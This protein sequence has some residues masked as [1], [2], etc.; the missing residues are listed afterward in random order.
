MAS[1]NAV[2]QSRIQLHLRIRASKARRQSL[3]AFL[4]EAIPAYKAPGGIG[5]RLLEDLRDPERFIEVIDYS[6]PAAFETDQVRVETDATMI[7]LLDR[8]RR[9]LDG[10]VEIET[11]KDITNEVGL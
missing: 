8:W 5:V 7:A 2:V 10:P 4:R 9:R 11:Y 3:L 6:S 1:Q